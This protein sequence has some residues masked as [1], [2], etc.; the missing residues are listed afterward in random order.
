MAFEGNSLAPPPPGGEQRAAAARALPE[1]SE[2]TV[3]QSHWTRPLGAGGGLGAA[4]RVLQ[5]QQT[6]AGAQQHDLYAQVSGLS[7]LLQAQSESLLQERAAIAALVAE[8]QP[9]LKCR[10]HLKGHVLCLQQA[11]GEVAGFNLMFRTQ[12]GKLQESQSHVQDVRLQQAQE[13]VFSLFQLI[14]QQA[15]QL[16]Q[17]QAQ[18][19][20]LQELASRAQLEMQLSAQ[21]Q[22]AKMQTTERK[23][24]E[25]QSQLDFHVAREKAL[26]PQEPPSQAPTKL[27]LQLAE[28][29]QTQ[30]ECAFAQRLTGLEAEL[31]EALE[32]TDAEDDEAEGGGNDDWV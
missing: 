16:Q 9:E 31:R 28:V 10:P 3:A 29:S 32:A 20:T 14:N 18:V 23:L 30:A 21:A 7:R 8:M 17:T 19:V 13:Q 26:V 25:L 4:Q 15:M 1:S 5:E 6:L 22:A 11:Q 12:L 27:D 2:V 24:R